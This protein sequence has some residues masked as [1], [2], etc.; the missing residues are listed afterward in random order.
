MP[1]LRREGPTDGSSPPYD[2][3][4]P[5]SEHLIELSIRLRR[6]F[7]AILVAAG[8]LSFIPVDFKY[9]I[10]LVSYF[11]RSIIAHVLPQEVT[12][13]GHTYHV[14]IAQYNP[15]A[16]FSLLLKSALVLGVLGASPV[17]IREIYEFV[18]P[19]L[20]P[21]ERRFL[22]WFL[23]VGLGLFAVGVTLAI[24]F[25]L[26]FAFKIMIVTSSAVVG[27]NK[28]VAFSDIEKLFD[29]IVLISIATGLAFE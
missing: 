2:V 13:R 16:G 28:L 6:I 24:L 14:Y 27:P 1:E 26:P 19:A 20:Y 9:Y 25:V 29:T 12:W 4:R 21:H 5:I 22:K 23:T 18:R 7:I 3:E 8:I 17:I 15:F 10:P 11:P